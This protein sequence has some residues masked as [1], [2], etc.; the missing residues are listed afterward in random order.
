MSPDHGGQPISGPHDAGDL[1]I[2]HVEPGRWWIVA[3]TG[4]PVAGDAACDRS[5]E[6]TLAAGDTLDWRVTGF[7]GA[8][9]AEGDCVV[10]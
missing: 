5:D 7:P 9:D 4:D 3:Y 10:P 8:Y 1:V 6:V 2:S